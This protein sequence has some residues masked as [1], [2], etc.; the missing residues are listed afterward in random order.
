MTNNVYQQKENFFNLWASYYDCLFTT[1]FYQ[2]IHRRLLEYVELQENAAVLDLGCGTGR[3]LNRLADQFPTVKGIGLDLSPSMLREARARN[4]HHKRLIFVSGRA[5][6]LSFADEQFD[7]VFLGTGAG[8][9]AT[10]DIPG[11]NLKGVYKSTDFLVRARHPTDT[12]SSFHH[13]SQGHFLK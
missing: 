9:E 7:A 13:T 11:E 3:L 8:V 2:A 1:V 12:G 10:M 6:S 5:E 4:K